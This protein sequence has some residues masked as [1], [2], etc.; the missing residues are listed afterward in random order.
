MP[1]HPFFTQQDG[2]MVIAHQGG[3]WLRPSN[4]LAAFDHAVGLGVDVLE[5]DIH[6]TKDG[7]I[8][9]RRR[10]RP[11]HRRQRC[12]QRDEFCRNSRVGCRPLLDR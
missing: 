9:M 11:H 1:E 3:E 4:T 12:H 10:P 6:Q 2:V 7:V 8:V 5:M